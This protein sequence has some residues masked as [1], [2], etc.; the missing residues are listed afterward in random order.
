V[1]VGTIRKLEAAG[2]VTLQVVAMDVDALV[3]AGIPRRFAKQILAYVR[4]A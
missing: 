1:G 4:R 2:V 3:A